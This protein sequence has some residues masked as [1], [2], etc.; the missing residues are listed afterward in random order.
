LTDSFP[1]DRDSCEPSAVRLAGDEQGK[2][3]VARGKWREAC[4]GHSSFNDST[5]QDQQHRPRMV[6]DVD[7]GEPAV[8]GSIR[9]VAILELHQGYP[10]RLGASP[11]PTFNAAST[12]MGIWME[13]PLNGLE[14]VTRISQ[15]PTTRRVPRVL[16]TPCRLSRAHP[17][18]PPYTVDGIAITTFPRPCLLASRKSMSTRRCGAS[19][20]SRSISSGRLSSYTKSAGRW[21]LNKWP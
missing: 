6:L 1:F 11:A 19:G 20:S 2:W 9:R 15:T 21:G 10:P 16:R 12:F 18:A 3:R 13:M 4:T 8:V 7:V 5:H 17:S 14:K